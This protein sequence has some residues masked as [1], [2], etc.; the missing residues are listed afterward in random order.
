MQL[1]INRKLI[2]SKTSLLIRISKRKMKKKNL[3]L[4]KMNNKSDGEL[5]VFNR[6]D[7]DTFTEIVKKPTNVWYQGYYFRRRFRM[8]KGL[9]ERIVEDVT[10]E[11]SFFQQRYDARGTLGFTPLQK[12]T[13][14][15]RQLAY[16]IPPD[17]LDGSFRMSA[18]IARDSLHFFC[19]TVIQFYGPKYLRKPTRN[20]ILQLQ[21]HHASVH[22][23]PGMLGSLDC[24]HWAWENCPTSYHG[25]F[26]R[27]PHGS[28]RK[29]F[30]RAQERARKDV[31]R[32]FGALKKRWFILKKPVA[33]LGVEKLQEIMYTCIILHNMII[34]DEGRAICAFDEEEIIPETQPIELGGEE[35]INRREEIHCTETFHNLRNDLVEHIYGVQNINLNLDPPDDPENEFSEN[36][37]M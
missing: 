32:A 2:P 30:K 14:A 19:K 10:R 5:Q 25:Q 36:D 4:M 26:T 7:E 16:G 6:E 21:A 12:C 28:R 18:R 23:F 20:D 29:K 27:A 1:L 8:L 34:E 13:A 9:F 33:Y 11:C 35:Y 3:K 37:F 22:G 31:E 17:A 15:L 24:L